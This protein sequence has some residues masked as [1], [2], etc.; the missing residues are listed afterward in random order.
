MSYLCLIR[1]GESTWNKA[2]AWTGQIDISLNE[3]GRDEAKKDGL[4]LKEYKFDIAYIS[5]LRRAQQTLDEIKN[6]IGVLDL[7]TIKDSALN[8]RDYGD[9]T[10]KNKQDVEKKYGEEQFL[11][12]R[13]G[14]NDKVPNGETLEDVY[15]RVIP[16]YKTQILPKIKDG[17]NVLVVAHGNSLRAL[18]KFLDNISDEDIQNFELE[19]GEV[20]IYKLDATPEIVSK[21]IRKV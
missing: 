5:K 4:L 1:H 8:E 9:L 18:I 14:W 2:G 3:E 7:P 17:K 6:V 10:G 15:N 20:Y 21:E 13:R 12:W 11:K 19:T 16:F